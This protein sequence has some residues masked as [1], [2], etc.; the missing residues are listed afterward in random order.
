MR[1]AQHSVLAIRFLFATA[2]VAGFV[3]NAPFAHAQDKAA[4]QKKLESVYSITQ[5]TADKTDIVTAGSILVLQKS[6]LVMTE[7]TKNDLNQNKYQDGKI[8]QNA[9][10][11]TSRFLKRIPGVAAPANA[12]NTRTFVKGEKMWLTKVEVKDNTV[13]LELFTDQMGDF[14]YRA[15]LTFFGKGPLPSPDQ[16]AQTVGEVFTVQPADNAAPTGDQQAAAP[17]AAAAPAPVAAPP[18][19]ADAAPAP[20]PPPPP[21]PDEPAAPPKT[22]SLGQTVDEVVANF[23]QPTKKAKVGNKDIYYY[24]DIKVTFVNGK[25]S[26]VQ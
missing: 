16:A 11:N 17:A 21:P 7:A 20:I 24:P 14:R 22:I 15:L 9:L 4:I 13:V 12:P 25:V 23:G 19:P 6:N 10:S 18:P 1:L 8:T 5:P 2:A 26:D 3:A